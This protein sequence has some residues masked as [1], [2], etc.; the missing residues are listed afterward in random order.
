MSSQFS[1]F[2]LFTVFSAVSQLA[3]AAKIIPGKV[4]TDFD[5]INGLASYSIPVD[6]APG[7]NNLSPSVS[8]DYLNS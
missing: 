6:V 3:L 5:V 7:R 2:I 8:L 4:P 1:K